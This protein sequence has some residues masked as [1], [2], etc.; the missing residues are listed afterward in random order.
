MSLEKVVIL[1]ADEKNK[2]F[3]KGMVPVK[4]YVKPEQLA[5]IIR[6]NINLT[7][8]VQDWLA[9]NNEAYKVLHDEEDV[10]E[11]L[12]LCDGDEFDAARES[13]E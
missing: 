13:H 9:A 3:R 12:D 1:E 11:I 8:A 4:F 7:M 6:L 10:D 2:R 5:E